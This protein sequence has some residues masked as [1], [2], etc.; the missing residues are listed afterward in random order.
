MTEDLNHISAYKF[1]DLDR[2]ALPVMKKHL[3]QAGRELGLR[4]TI[5]LS[6]E[7]VNVFLSGTESQLAEYQTVLSEYPVFHDLDYR[8]TS[9]KDWPYTR[10]LVR[11]KNA[12]IPFTDDTLDPARV[13]APHLSPEE[14]KRWYDEGHDMIVLDTRNDYEIRLGKFKDALELP[15][16][17][18]T[19]FSDALDQLPPEARKKPV[20]TYCTGGVRCE[21]AA[22]YMQKEGFENVYQLEGGIINYFERVGGEHFEGECFVFDKRVGIDAELKE[23]GTIQCYGCRNPLTAEEQAVIAGRCPHCGASVTHAKGTLDSCSEDR[24]NVDSQS[25]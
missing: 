9:A 5:L 8:Q 11:I 18:F 7:G 22:T 20:V 10:F 16:K 1:F 15:I 14:F 12:I 6:T 19:D 2:D 23:T 17:K 24:F 13:T 25:E 4:G 21:K 3:V